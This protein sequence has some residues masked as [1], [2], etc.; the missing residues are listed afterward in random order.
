M[1]KMHCFLQPVRT[2]FHT[3]K[4]TCNEWLSRNRSALVGVALHIG[5]AS[6]AIR[7]GYALLQDL[8]DLGNIKVICFLQKFNYFLSITQ[9]FI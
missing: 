7:H 9:V 6:S 8:L 2:F 4:S 1:K 3:N 5:M